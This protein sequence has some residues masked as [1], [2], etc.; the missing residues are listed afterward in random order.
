ME[1][2]EVEDSEIL[3]V[4]ILRQQEGETPLVVVEIYKQL[5]EEI[6]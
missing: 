2:S 3:V 5:V 4:E 6:L 1:D